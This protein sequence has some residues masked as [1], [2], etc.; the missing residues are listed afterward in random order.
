LELL[1]V[2]FKTTKIKEGCAM[3]KDKDVK[4]DVKKKPSKTVKEKK[5]AKKIKKAEKV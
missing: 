4:K 5:E 3:G 1:R 2:T